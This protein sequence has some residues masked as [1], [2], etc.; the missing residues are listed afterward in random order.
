MTD[1]FSMSQI[2]TYINEVSKNPIDLTFMS[3]LMEYV[4][5]NDTLLMT[6]REFDSC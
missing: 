5:K 1:W 3:E 2:I 4:G 6:S